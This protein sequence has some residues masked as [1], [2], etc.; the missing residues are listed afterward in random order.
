MCQSKYTDEDA[1]QDLK[2]LI[3]NN[4]DKR[5]AENEFI[6]IN[7]VLDPMTKNIFSQDDAVDLI[8]KAYN[9]VVQKGIL[10]TTSTVAA[11]TCHDSE[12]LEGQHEQELT[13]QV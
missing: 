1:M 12:L 9:L 11:A 4:V 13:E 7:Q 3:L 8:Q 10:T 2:R 6:R 5:L